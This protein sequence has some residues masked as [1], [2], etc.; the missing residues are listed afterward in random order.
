MAGPWEKYAAPES[1]PWDKYAAPNIEAQLSNAGPADA[2]ATN[3]ATYRFPDELRAFQ[4]S[5]E[6]L[7]TKTK[8]PKELDFIARNYQGS[9]EPIPAARQPAAAGGIRRGF[10]GGAENRA[11][12]RAAASSVVAPFA[13]A[14]DMTVGSIIPGAYQQFGYPF[15]RAFGQ[16]PEEAT[17]TVGRFSAPFQ[18]PFGRAFGV[19][20]RPEYK[21]EASQQLIEFI[22]QNVDKGAQWLS[23]KTGL[24]AQDIANITGN[25]SLLAGPT[26]AKIPTKLGE[27]QA[28]KAIAASRQSWEDL[29]RIEATQAAQK[30]GIFLNPEQSNPGKVNTIVGKL[31]GGQNVNDALSKKNAPRWTQLA[32]EE[33]E[34]PKNSV[35]EPAAFEQARA[36]VAGPYNRISGLGRVDADTEFLAALDNLGAAETIG[37]ASSDAVAKLAAQAKARAAS[38]FDGP[39]ILQSIKQRRYDAQQTYKRENSA[40]PPSAEELVIADANMKLANALEDLA[41]RNVGDTRFKAELQTARAKMATTYAYERATNFATGK[42]DPNVIAKLVK[43]DPDRYT[44][45]IKEIGQI[46]GNFPDIADVKGSTVSI[47]TRLYRSTPSVVLGTALGSLTGNPLGGAITGMVAGGI[48]GNMLRRGI[49]KPGYQN[50]MG[51]PADNRLLR[52]DMPAVNNLTDSPLLETPQLSPKQRRAF[53]MA[54]EDMARPLPPPPPPPPTTG[55]IELEFDPRTNRLRPVEPESTLPVTTDLESALNK[56]RQGKAAGP[57]QISS[58]IGRRSKTVVSPEGKVETV[59]GFSGAE[60]T[61]A[62][63]AVLSASEKLAWDNAKVNMSIVDPTMKKLTIEQFMDREWL[64]KTVKKAREKGDAFDQIATRAT[65]P[66]AVALARRNREQMMDFAEELEDRL[67]AMPTVKYGQGPKTRAAKT[68]PPVIVKATRLPPEE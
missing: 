62:S 4:F 29:P 18:K 45:T 28:D 67:R 65:D 55:G 11:A 10:S 54:R 46:A 14:A 38:P 17:A 57:I 9:P 15:A 68:L 31:A 50:F 1:G 30:H 27:R 6:M 16:T 41:V 25:V 26:V 3:G 51:V 35:L 33:M 2:Q 8:D 37:G 23:E 22:G 5:R 19:T 20:E 36:N 63:T 24:P 61:G 39:L 52:A 43:D 60:P 64:L 58:G 56:L 42:V 48:G 13:S 49:A 53:E 21:G 47:P 12:T 7:S 59:P 34:L 66:N 44:G 32:K 40:S